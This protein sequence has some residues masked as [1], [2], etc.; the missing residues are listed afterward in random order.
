LGAGLYE[1]KGKVSLS[2]IPVLRSLVTTFASDVLH[3]LSLHLHNKNERS[4]RVT[5]MLKHT[6][7]SQLKDA[8]IIF[9]DYILPL[10]LPN[11]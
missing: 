11:A 8:K 9:T 4:K 6:T 1:N 5:L 7:R 2:V 10:P 3:V